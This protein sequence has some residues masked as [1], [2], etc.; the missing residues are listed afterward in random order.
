M[1]KYHLIV[2]LLS[3]IFYF[4]F[5][6]AP[7][8]TELPED[9]PF[10]THIIISEEKW[11]FGTIKQGR[12][13]SHSFFIINNGEAP[14]E[15]TKIRSSC[16]CIGYEI[17]SKEIDPGKKARLEITFNSQ[18]RRGKQ[19]KKVY[20]HFN[21]PRQPIV[22]LHITGH[23]KIPP[24]PIIQTSPTRWYL[25]KVNVDASPQKRVVITNIGEKAL[26]I[27]N[28]ETSS[29]CEAELLTQKI[30]LPGEKRYIDVTLKPINGKQDRISEYIIIH[31]NDPKYPKLKILFSGFVRRETP[32][33]VVCM[34]LFFSHDCESCERIIN[35]FIPKLKKKY[36]IE[37]NYKDVNNTNDYRFL[38]DLEKVY[39]NSG[40]LFPIVF[41]GNFILKGEKEVKEQLEERIKHYLSQGGISLPET[42]EINPFIFNRDQ[43]IKPIYLAFFTQPG[44]K[45]CNRVKYILRYLEK[46]Y[47]NITIKTFNPK[48]D[49]DYQIQEAISELIEIP[50]NKRHLLPTICIGNNYLIKDEITDA[51]LT[52]LIEKYKDSGSRS[53]WKDAKNIQ[54]KIH[55]KILLKFKSLTLF[56]IVTA[57]LL[58]GINPCAFA[59]IIFLISYLVFINKKKKHIIIIGASFTLAVFMT[60]L[61]SGLGAWQIIQMLGI[62]PFLSRCFYFII[63]ALVLILSIYSFYDYYLFRKGNIKKMKLQLPMFIKK[64]IHLVIREKVK[65][66]NYIIYAFIMGFFISLLE[67]VCTGQVYLPTIAFA[68]RTSQF[69]LQAII[70]LIIYNFMFIIPLIIVFSL[71]A[72]GIGSEKLQLLLKRNIGKTKLSLA[73][74]FFLLA[75]I[76]IFFII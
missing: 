8:A 27:K 5:L 18:G 53:L 59:T 35:N 65:T 60:Y 74:F 2:C 20:M 46:I 47:P 50:E 72:Y 56:I 40:E 36:P 11:D 73:I 42:K 10:Q 63:I 23:I 22:T 33:P 48:I 15:I 55:T 64:R 7:H 61:L 58:D 29:G 76:L 4:A 19:H 37:I 3:L 44:C 69:G 14:L 21:T 51:N 38:L 26:L 70:Y 32:S 16:G 68:M 67:L 39:R 43:M 41:I 6:Q 52:E 54:E 57:G 25:G 30:V 9:K 24:C 49:K 12:E 62:F 71:T 28:I 45:E 66:K 75:A 1:K 17:S 31:S 34:Y 13:V